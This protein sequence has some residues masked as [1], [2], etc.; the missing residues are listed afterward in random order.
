MTKLSQWKS[1]LKLSFLFF[2]YTF[3]AIV[4]Q[5]RYGIQFFILP[6]LGLTTFMAVY[7]VVRMFDGNA[8]AIF[9]PFLVFNVISYPLGGAMQLAYFTLLDSSEASAFLASPIGVNALF[10]E[11]LGDS[12]ATMM[13]NFIAIVAAAGI[14]HPQ[15]HGLNTIYG[16]L[17]LFMLLVPG[18]KLGVAIGMKFVFA[19]QLSQFIMAAF[20]LFLILPSGNPLAWVGLPFS[21]ALDLLSGKAALPAMLYGSV[22]TILWWAMAEFVFRW[23]YNQYRLGKGVDRI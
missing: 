17:L 10:A 15:F 16:L 3:T 18:V 6:A 23:S 4:R 7:A 9:Y 21:A 20:F 5:A 11:L 12:W 2:F 19:N 1:I 8:E 13:G 14:T 22:G